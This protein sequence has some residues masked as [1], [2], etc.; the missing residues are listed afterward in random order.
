MDR[1]FV[2][3]AGDIRKAISGVR[4]NQIIEVG[5]NGFQI[6]KAEGRISRKVRLNE[7]IDMMDKGMTDLEIAS[8]MNLA[9]ETIRRTRVQINPTMKIRKPKINPDSIQLVRGHV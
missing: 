6:I 4:D 8:V 5:P 7:I 2:T 1:F 3:T 9:E